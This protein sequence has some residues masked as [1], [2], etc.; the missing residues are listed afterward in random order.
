MSVVGTPSGPSFELV[1]LLE[2][3][4]KLTSQHEELEARVDLLE[5]SETE[6]ET[7]RKRERQSGENRF[8]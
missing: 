6:T 7:E 8:T 2:R 4:G 3:L 5:V 1:D